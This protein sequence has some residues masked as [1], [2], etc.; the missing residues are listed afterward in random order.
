VRWLAD[1]CISPGILRALRHAGHDVVSALEQ[2]QGFEDIFLLE[3]AARE[4]RI[5]LTED[6]DFGELLFQ[7]G[8][9]LDVLGVVFVRMPTERQSHKLTRLHETIGQYGNRLVGNYVVIGETRTRIR[10]LPDRSAGD[11]KPG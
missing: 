7:G 10:P 1:E 4:K 6:R 8:V 9:Q 5:L 2:F 3:L 11:D